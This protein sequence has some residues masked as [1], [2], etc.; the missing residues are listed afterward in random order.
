MS[1]LTGLVFLTNQDS[2]ND[3]RFRF[4]GANLLPMNPATYIWRINPVQQT[5]YYTTFFWG[6]GDGSFTGNTGYYGAHPYPQGSSSGVVHNWEVSTEGNDFVVDDNAHDT[7]VVK[8]VWYTQALKAEIVSGGVLTTK[9]YWDLPDTTK[10]ITRTSTN[11]APAAL[12]SPELTWGGNA[13]ASGNECL[14]GTLRGIQAYSA[15]LSLAN[16]LTEAANHTV[17]TPQTVSGISNIWYMNQNPTPADVSDKSGA[18]HNPTWANANRPT[19]YSLEVPDVE[20]TYARALRLRAKQMRVRA[21][22][23]L[24]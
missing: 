1:T 6:E 11:G 3:I 5:G 9:F 20:T 19:L 4:T 24:R 12:N 2:N 23:R 18:G 8:D 13:W 15:A 21:K 22:V 10:V 16:I 7:T 14:S 17:N